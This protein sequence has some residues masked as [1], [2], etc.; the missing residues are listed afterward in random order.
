MHAFIAMYEHPTGLQFLEFS[1]IISFENYY[2]YSIIYRDK[3]VIG[4]SIIAQPYLV[5][6]HVGK[7]NQVDRLSSIIY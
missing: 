6:I 3:R 1:K 5:C 4:F 2:I 7:I